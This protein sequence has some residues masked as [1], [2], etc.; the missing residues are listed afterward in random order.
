MTYRITLSSNPKAILLIVFAVA[1]PVGA[2]LSFFVLPIFLSIVL[3][4]LGGYVGYFLGK[5]VYNIFISRIE[6]SD[7]GLR[8][9][10][11]KKES[12]SLRW[13]QIS[14]AG[15]CEEERSKP[16]AFVY[17]EDEDKLLTVPGEYD[18]FDELVATLRKHV[19]VDEIE[20]EHGETIA[21]YLRDR[22]GLKEQDDD[23]EDIDVDD[24]EG[25]DVDD[26]EGIDVDDTEGID[27]D[28]TG[29]GEDDSD[30]AD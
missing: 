23:T 21:S 19:K 18:G 26:T 28:T 16:S 20:L 25:I 14:H 5:Y 17:S 30:D 27:V 1:I 29:G 13:D 22:M 24:T 4:V 15:H 2:I 9:Q 8:F 6:T 3:T 11:T 12:S 7:E 10:T